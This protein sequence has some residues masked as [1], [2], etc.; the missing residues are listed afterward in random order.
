MGHVTVL[1]EMALMVLYFLLCCASK[2]IKRKHIIY[3]VAIAVDSVNR[4]ACGIFQV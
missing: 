3:V 1:T 2:M 4:Q